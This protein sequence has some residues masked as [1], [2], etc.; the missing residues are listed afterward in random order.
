MTSDASKPAPARPVG[1]PRRPGLPSGSG[2]TSSA[3]RSTGRAGGETVTGRVF[4]ILEVF[5]HDHPALTLTEIARAAALP[6][7]TA[8][9]LV[10]ELAAWGALERGADGAYRIGLRL[11]EVGSLAPRSVGLRERAMPFLED[12]YE[13]TRQNVQ[14]AVRD[15]HE[16]VYVER[17]AHPDAV[18]LFSRV[19]GRWP[20]HGTGVGQVL[21]AFAPPVVQ[22]SVLAAPLTSFT[23]RTITDPA[24]LRRTLAGIRR[25][26]V[27]VC[28]G[29][30]DLASLSVAAPVRGEGDAVVAAISVVVPSPSTPGGIEPRTLVP[31][32]RAA[33][34]GISR[35]IGAPTP[36][37]TPRTLRTDVPRPSS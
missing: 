7:S 2:L 13:A 29:M 37:R 17:L 22:E 20:L 6:V 19:G 3:A 30:I 5:D 18:R 4:S 15:G 12:L 16:G 23:A 25:D 34:R 26:G 9:R 36:S 21:L 35:A 27:A 31:A 28:D 10:G 14:L 8:H 33:A 11:W 1:R 24:V 32:V